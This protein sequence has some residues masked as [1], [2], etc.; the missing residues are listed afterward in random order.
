[1]ALSKDNI[2]AAIAA[3]KAEVESIDVP[4]WGGAVFIRRLDGRD[5]VRSGMLSENTPE[6]FPLRVVALSVC[7]EDGAPLFDDPSAL[8]EADAAVVTR[9]FGECA[10]VNGWTSEEMDRMASGFAAAPRTDSSTA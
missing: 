8:D 1:M 7:D 5:L 6:D 2:V 10:R 3:R 9:L 4:E